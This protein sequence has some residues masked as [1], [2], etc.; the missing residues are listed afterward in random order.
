MRVIEIGRH[1]A[2]LPRGV[3]ARRERSAFI[4][5]PGEPEPDRRAAVV[6]G[7]LQHRLRN[8]LGLVNIL[9][10]RTAGEHERA[11]DFLPVFQ[12]RLIALDRVQSL[13]LQAPDNDRLN[14]DDMLRA[15]IEAV[16]GIDPAEDRPYLHLQGPDDVVLNAS[17]LQILALAIHELATNSMKHGVLGTLQGRLSLRWSTIQRGDQQ[18]LAL[19]WSEKSLIERPPSAT[20]GGFGREL[21]ER[22]LPLQFGARTRYVASAHHVHCLIELPVRAARS[23]S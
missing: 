6:V 15:E 4:D 20:T 13:L 7:E 18:W 16:A 2:K 5:P 9:A 17:T 3:K 23:A 8:L 19:E 14:L 1:S 21:I 10:E 12:A 22:A 11:E